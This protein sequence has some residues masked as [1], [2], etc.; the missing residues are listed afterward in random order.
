MY[1]YN[2]V[3][4]S[5]CICTLRTN[6]LGISLIGCQRLGFLSNYEHLLYIDET[7]TQLAGHATS[8]EAWAVAGAAVTAVLV[9]L[10]VVVVQ[11][12][13]ICHLWRYNLKHTLVILTTSNHSN[14]HVTSYCRST[15]RITSQSQRYNDVI[16]NSHSYTFARY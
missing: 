1:S 15:S 8:L 10:L 13:V 5:L 16:T 3:P 12:A 2:F 11:S 9:L 4:G 7:S 14:L 6:S